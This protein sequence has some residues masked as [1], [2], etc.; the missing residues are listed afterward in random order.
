M[1]RVR[2]AGEPLVVHRSARVAL[3]TSAAQRNR[4]FAL[5]VS[6]GDVWACVLQLN[7]WRRHRGDRPVVGYQELCRELTRA[8]SG[9][10]GELSSVGARSVLRRYSDAWFAA[11][12]ERKAGNGSARYPRRRRRL[13]PLRFYS[14]TFSVTRD[15]VRLPVASGCRPLVV[16]LSRQIPYPLE[17][18]RSVTLLAD[19]GRLCLEVCAEVPVAIYAPEDAPDPRRVGGVDLG[20][21]HPFAVAGPGGKAL[22]VSGRALRAESRLHIAERKARSRAVGRRAPAR[23]QRGSRR[24][25]KYQRRTRALEAPSTSPPGTRAA[26]GPC[27]CPARSCTVEPVSTSPV[28]AV[29]GVTRAAP[30]GRSADRCVGPGLPWPAPKSQLRG[31]ARTS[32][33]RC[34]RINRP[35]QNVQRLADTALYAGV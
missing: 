27:R 13:M 1:P 22:L 8:G 4:L 15:R 20:V 11:A 30:G 32:L 7:D 3:H 9:C 16:R 6:G 2:S 21:I 29:P 18:V 5:L 34:L 35:C 19:R 26:E 28:P 14:G 33:R 12:K 24:W 17:Q 25:R 23:G 31:V 10:F